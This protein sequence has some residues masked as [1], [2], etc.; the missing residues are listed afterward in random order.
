MSELG[1]REDEGS[2]AEN[3]GSRLRLGSRSARTS[4]R[5]S[6]LVSASRSVRQTESSFHSY[7]TKPLVGQVVGRARSRIGGRREGGCRLYWADGYSYGLVHV[8]AVCRARLVTR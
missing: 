4:E 8:G 7:L 3:N 1:R 5:A 6:S 2:S